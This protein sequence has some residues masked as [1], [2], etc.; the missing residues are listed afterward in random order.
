MSER[1][2]RFGDMQTLA[3][4]AANDTVRAGQSGQPH[5][6]F[7]FDRQLPLR[8]THSSKY[9]G[10]KKT[11]GVDDPDLIPM[12]VAD[13]D[14][15]AAPPIQAALRAEVERGYMGY[16]GDAATANTAVAQWIEARHGWAV[17]PGWVR[18]THGVISGFGDVIATYSEPGDGVIVFSPV[19]H[20]F[21]R[22]IRAMGREAVESPMA[23]RDGRYHMDLEALA[24]TLTGREKIV[25]FC[26]PHNPGG[27]IWSQEEIQG[28]A[29]F[30]ADHDLMLISD[31]IHMDLVFPDAE[32]V[33][34]IVAAPQVAERL[35]VLTAASKGFNLAGLETGLLIA[36]DA[37]VR[38][39]LDRKML[40]RES[41]PNRFGITAI[42]A[43]F[44]ECGEWSD[45]V[46]AY[47][48]ENFRIFADRIGALPGVSVMEMQSTYLVWVDFNDLG[49]A[50]NELLE[51]FLK[52]AKVVPT[53]GAQFGLGGEG[54]MRFNVALP[55]PTLMTAISRIEDAFADLQ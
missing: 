7:D 42:R 29:Q 34:T 1:L 49:M 55:R 25:T 40:D 52:Q 36:P 32:F 21:F 50:E 14:F 3:A 17:D 48:A 47:I 15:A 39:L 46:R 37:G 31:E 2:A 33:P 4:A 23:I 24:A 13:M 12:W 30:C 16:F 9:D 20:S 8:G 44:S 22:Q 41:S 45:A 19:Y 26:S 38:A 27:R 18:Y 51:R 54:H 6:T 43:A 10:I 35:V 11:Y 5:M 28:L 53:A